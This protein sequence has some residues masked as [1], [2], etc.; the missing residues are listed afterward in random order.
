[1]AFE[2]T[3]A[4]SVASHF[5]LCVQFLITEFSILL[6]SLTLSDEFMEFP[7]LS[8]QLSSIEFICAIIIEHL[9]L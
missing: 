5:P 8:P 1:M 2:Y 9:Y 3:C 6:L 7:V 4:L